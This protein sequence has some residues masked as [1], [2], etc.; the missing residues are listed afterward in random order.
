[1]ADF[2]GDMQGIASKLLKDFKQGVIEYI[3]ITPGIGSP[4]NPGVPQET[5]YPI[6]AVARGVKFKYVDGSHI[7]GTDLQLTMPGNGVIPE[8]TGFIRMDGTKYK[9]V[10][11]VPKPAAGTPVAFTVI[12][13]K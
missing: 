8:M 13:R 5:L 7:V 3:A 12:F 6:D 1:M 10:Q 9:I 11:I 4:D 2:Y